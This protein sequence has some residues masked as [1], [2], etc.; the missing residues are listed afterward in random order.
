MDEQQ[1]EQEGSSLDWD[2]AFKDMMN[3]KTD[4][5]IRIITGTLK[6]YSMTQGG[7]E[8]HFS[9]GD[10]TWSYAFTDV[11]AAELALTIMSVI[12]NR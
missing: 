5:D 8:L 10:V 4:D 2:A 3:G 7:F 6:L 9:D 12:S 11:Q 1:F